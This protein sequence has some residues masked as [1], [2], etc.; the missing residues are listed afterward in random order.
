MTTTEPYERTKSGAWT[1]ATKRRIEAERAEQNAKMREQNAQRAA[2]WAALGKL[3]E[4]TA[5]FDAMDFSDEPQ[6]EREE[7][8]VRAAE[9][10]ERESAER[11]NEEEARIWMLTF[12]LDALNRRVYLGLDTDLTALETLEQ[13]RNMLEDMEPVV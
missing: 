1:A 5:E 6:T 4:A 3:E 12:V 8:L 10:S 7:R 11:D 9:K 2:R 13:L